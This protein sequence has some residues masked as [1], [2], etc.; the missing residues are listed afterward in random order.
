MAAA[1]KHTTAARL[2]PCKPACGS[3]GSPLWVQPVFVHVVLRSA[4]QECGEGTDAAACQL[5][6]YRMRGARLPACMYRCL[7]ASRCLLLA[8]LDHS[9]CRCTHRRGGSWCPA[10]SDRRQSSTALSAAEWRGRR[11]RRR[12]FAPRSR[13]HARA[14]NALRRQHGR[15]CW[16]AAFWCCCCCGCCHACLLVVRARQWLILPEPRVPAARLLVGVHKGAQRPDRACAARDRQQPC[17]AGSACCVLLQSRHGCCE[18]RRCSCRARDGRPGACAAACPP[19]C[20]RAPWE[21]ESVSPVVGV[22]CCTWHDL[23]GRRGGGGRRLV[24]SCSSPAGL[25]S[26]LPEAR[27]C[28]EIRRASARRMRRPRGPQAGH[29]A[30][31]ERA[32]HCLRRPGRAGRWHA[33]KAPR[34]AHLE[35]EQ[36][37]VRGIACSALAA[38]LR[39]AHDLTPRRSH[40]SGA[41]LMLHNYDDHMPS[42]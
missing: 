24:V 38:G 13:M 34:R 41:W 19:R 18:S 42:D 36:I 7:L 16:H 12:R 4:N 39:T 11:R 26:T 37:K 28:V 33:L 5:A 32:R 3:G 27:R 35:R 23:Q 9:Q 20:M 21:A 30:R 14:S 31:A 40:R 17:Q 22:L 29:E 25:G 6:G 10:I 1:C 2:A 8:L 15:A